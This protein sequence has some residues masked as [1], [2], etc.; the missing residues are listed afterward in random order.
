V[1]RFHYDAD[2]RLTGV[3]EETA[4]GSTTYT[5]AADG[6]RTGEVVR[7]AGG[8]VL[9]QRRYVHDERGGL[10]GIVDELTGQAIATYTTDRE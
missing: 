3:D 2:E 6:T 1:R 8:L 7:G 4:G 5:I 9:D 10:S